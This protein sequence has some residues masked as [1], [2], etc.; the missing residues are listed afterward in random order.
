MT[1]SAARRLSIGAMLAASAIAFAQQVSSPASGEEEVLEMSPFEV[2]ADREGTYDAINSNSITSFNV[3]LG[4]MPISADIFTRTFM[5]DTASTT[6]ENMLQEYAAGSGVGSAAGDV[7]GIPINQPMDRGGG[8]SVSSGVQLRGLGASVVKQDSF[9][10]PSPAGTGLNS[11]FGV[12]RVEILNGP[13]ALLYGNGGGGGVIN[14]ISKQ[15]RFGKRPGGAIRFSIDDY[16]NYIGQVDYETGSRRFA[17]AISATKQ[18]LGDSRDWI[19]GPLEGAYAQ[20]AARL[21]RRTTV[22]LTGKHT[23]F[24][25]IAQRNIRLSSTS[26][27]TDARHNQN[28]RYLLGSGQMESSRT[29]PSGAG[30][31]GNGYIN[32]D[33]I[34]SYMGEMGGEESTAQLAS[35]VVETRWASWLSTQVSAGYQSKS[36]RLFNG[37]GNTF[38]APGAQGNPLPEE[39]TIQVGG[40]KRAAWSS[41]PSRS[42]S[43]RFSALLANNL[44]N[45]KAH[46]QT[47]F[48]ADFT[49]AHYA[50]VDYGYYRADENWDVLHNSTGVRMRMTNPYWSVSEGPVKHPVSW[51]GRTRITVDGQNYVAR[52]MNLA[53]P[54]LVSPSNPQGVTDTQLYIHSRAI[55]RGIYGVNFTQWGRD[56]ALTTLLGLRYVS[57]HNRQL[58]S[59]AIP[60]IE[61]SDES[62]SFSAGVN[63]DL[64]PR[65]RIY[66]LLSD[67]YN[68]PGVLLT[69]PADPCGKPAPIAHSFGQE[70]GLKIGD[71]DSKLSGSISFY[72]LQSK[73]EPYAIRSQIRDAINPNGINGR[74]RDATGTVIAVDKDSYGVQAALSASPA[75]GW[76]MRLSAAYIRGTV[77]TNTSYRTLYN[78]QFH[79]NPLGQV[80]YRDGSLVYVEGRQFNA[81]P[82]SPGMPGYVP[83]TIDMMSDP[84]NLYYA[85]PNPANGR[86]E[87]TGIRSLLTSADNSG[88]PI[89]TGM[90]GLP[91]SSLQLTGV[92]PVESI[93]TS[94]VGD[95]TTGYPEISFNFTSIHTIQNGF[96][97]G[98]RYGGSANVSWRTRDYYYYSGGYT[99][100]AKRELFSR[101]TRTRFNLMLGYQRKFGKI[102]WA[103][104]LNVSNLFNTYEVLIRPDGVLGY[105]GYCDAI[106]S[107][108]PR[109]YSWTNTIKF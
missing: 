105:S 106:Y 73:D 61:A 87:S 39:W 90:S 44:P 20:I 14:V 89:T 72:E 97:K 46:S 70:V 98:F 80:T 55:S 11:I 1:G 71:A 108:Q 7:N 6:L 8:D 19:G 25:R 4:K 27:E 101:P 64:F 28:I 77:G 83:L 38:Y 18:R 26:V 69:V 47:I 52:I 23:H 67:T 21:T 82:G 29:G 91:I 51:R 5:E 109:T 10:L 96:L 50:N 60:A 41:Q 86:I 81:T 45:N 66:A 32:W 107:A 84:D 65:L 79:A 2:T 92:A 102:T 34:D 57:A 76:R 30:V 54:D 56:A 99:P 17:I 95:K 103:S 85:D 48:G 74:Y 58:P 93:V 53:N 75:R 16:G 9:M 62:L 78:D 59:T 49:E 12:E 36:S 68:L 3:E 40:S 31:I 94:K 22:R 88:N 63:Y 100:E 15:A 42:M 13:Q 24:D 43:F 33:N 104:Q 37:S 35:M